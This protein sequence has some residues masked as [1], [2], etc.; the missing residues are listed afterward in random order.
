M[1]NRAALRKMKF[2]KLANT[3]EKLEETD[4]QTE[5]VAILADLFEKSNK[6]NIDAICYL[7]LGDFGPGYKDTELGIGEA[8]IQKAIAQAGDLNKEKVEEKTKELGDLG[9]VAQKLIQ[10]GKS[11][12]TVNRVRDSLE[13]IS[14]LSGEGSQEEKIKSLTNLFLNNSSTGRKYIGRIAQGKMRLGIGEMTILDGLAKAFFGSKEK[15]KE[16][17]HAYNV[18]SDLGHVATIL[19]TSGLAGVKRIRVALNRPLHPML[20]QRV[21]R[22]SEIKKKIGSEKI[23]VEEK[24]D[25]SRTQVHKNGS[26]IKLF[27]RRLNDVS[28]EFPE[29]IEDV[30]KH[31]SAE[32]VILDGE[33]VAYDFEK[34]TYVPFQ[35]LMQRRRKYD[36]GEYAKKIP[37]KYMV[38]DLLYLEGSSF[39]KKS[40]PKR[41]R[42][43]EEIVSSR[44]RIAPSGRIV[45]SKPD[46]IEDFFEKSLEKNLEG[47][48]CKAYDENSYYE[49]GAR[50]W[51][52]IKWKKGYTAELSDTLD[53]VVV[54]SYAGKGSRAGTYGSLLCAAY[55][56]EEDIFETVSKLGAGFTDIELKSLPDKFKD[57][58]SSKKPARVKS[59][60]DIEPD[61]WFTPKTVVEVRGSE[62][63]QSPVHTCGMRTLEKGLALRFPRFQ[64]WRPEKAPD[65]ATTTQEIIEIYE[66]Q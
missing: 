50:G 16:L 49:A 38:F 62:L 45:T 63:T 1:G 2:R 32:K 37:V 15:R 4:S 40:Y 65:Q 14:Q 29:I 27:S 22:L 61:Q 35:K 42:K 5:M 6:E 43:L 58:E 24:Y 9:K 20:A 41:R 8:M 36:V 11:E 53:L 60:K 64:R 13:E 28:H 48:V 26:N 19:S 30:Q 54:G 10:S 25:G 59:T 55:N 46:K 44:K 21:S 51:Q 23:S 57:Y 12:L 31:V 34:G 18:C 66:K 56:H 52:W 7:L 33:A 47:V 39:L 3:M 17:E